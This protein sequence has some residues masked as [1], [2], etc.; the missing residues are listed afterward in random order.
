MSEN[1]NSIKILK[2]KSGTLVFIDTIDYNKYLAVAHR[3]GELIVVDI[4][5]GYFMEKYCLFEDTLVNMDSVLIKCPNRCKIEYITA[6]FIS[7]ENI[8]I[9]D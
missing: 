5:S 3:N 2:D 7:R 8:T 9:G 4:N 1:L 6:P